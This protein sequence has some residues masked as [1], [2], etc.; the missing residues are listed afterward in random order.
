MPNSNPNPLSRL[1]SATVT[2]LVSLAAQT[3]AGVKTFT[4]KLIAAAGL[5]VTNATG[6]LWNTNGS[7]ASDVVVKVGTSVA[8][9]TVNATAKLLSIRTGLNGGTEVEKVLVYK[10]GQADFGGAVRFNRDLEDT[11]VSTFPAR[12]LS[13]AP[14][15]GA[16]QVDCYTFQSSGYIMQWLNQGNLR[17]T[18]SPDGR[19]DQYGT[20]SSGT[21]GA[22]TINKPTGKSA[23][24]SGATTVVIT[25]SLVATTSRVLVTF[26]GDHGAARWWVVVGSGSF[27][28]TLASAASANTSFSWSVANIL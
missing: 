22:A 14:S 26:H 11:G 18:L 7:G 6:S 20:D 9:G 25:N 15:G 8:D 27:T 19:L 24:A 12:L 1:A 3:F 16:W 21:P 23:I 10:N 28:V 13:R 4:S 2:G 17:A 5:E